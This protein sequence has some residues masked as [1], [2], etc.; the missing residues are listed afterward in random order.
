MK[1]RIRLGNKNLNQ[2]RLAEGVRYDVTDP[3]NIFLLEMS[4][5]ERRP[6]SLFVVV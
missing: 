2:T 3:L 1:N 4:P 6:R 5:V